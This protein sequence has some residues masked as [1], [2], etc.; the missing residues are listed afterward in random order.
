MSDRHYKTTDRKYRDK[1][2]YDPHIISWK[3]FYGTRERVIWR[4]CISLLNDISSISIARCVL[5]RQIYRFNVER[6][7]AN[8]WKHGF[9]RSIEPYNFH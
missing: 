5:T 7:T 1:K 9:E 3:L 2:R 6:Q 8:E 4:T